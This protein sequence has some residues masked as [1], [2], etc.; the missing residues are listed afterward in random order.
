MRKG[1]VFFLKTPHYSN[2]PR[3]PREKFLKIN[4]GLGGEFWEKRE[5]EKIGILKKFNTMAKKGKVSKE[6]VDS[7][8]TPEKTLDGLIRTMRQ[9]LT[10]EGLY[11]PEMARQ[12]E[13]TASTLMVFRVVRDVAI[14]LNQD[15]TIKE[16]SRE[17]D[18]RIKNNPVIYQ[19]IQVADL[20]QRNLRA[21]NMNKE[22]TR[23]KDDKVNDDEADPLALLMK[24]QKEDD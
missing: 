22:L 16:T 10:K 23:G 24:E 20:L 6:K 1:G 21:L 3:L 8:K 14:R 9:T 17:G 18:A 5:N 12:V 19:Y 4:L 11:R 13:L 2:P 7:G 15:V